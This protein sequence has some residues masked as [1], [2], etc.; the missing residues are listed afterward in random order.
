MKATTTP[1]FFSPNSRRAGASTIT[2]LTCMSKHSFPGNMPG[3]GYVHDNAQNTTKTPHYCIVS[4]IKNLIQ[5]K[6]TNPWT[7][8]QIQTTFLSLRNMLSCTP[9]KQRKRN[10]GWFL[11]VVLWHPRFLRS[12]C[13]THTVVKFY[14]VEP[15]FL[16][17]RISSGQTNRKLC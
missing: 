16:L 8:T 10:K 17:H 15:T 3:P 7:W 1:P 9:K 11:C 12:V 13:P 6:H 14:F 4:K 5:C 2:L